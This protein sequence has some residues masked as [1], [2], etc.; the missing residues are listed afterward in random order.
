MLLLVAWVP[1]QPINMKTSDPGK[2]IDKTQCEYSPL[3]R[4]PCGVKPQRLTEQTENARVFTSVRASVL[5][6]P[7]GSNTEYR[8]KNLDDHTL[9]DSTLV[10]S[11][12]TMRFTADACEHYRLA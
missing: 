12:N 5:A 3:A 10:I 6:Q 2:C 1:L 9:P 8:N 11:R 4:R 7:H